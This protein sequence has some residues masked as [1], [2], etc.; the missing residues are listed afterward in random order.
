MAYFIFFFGD[1]VY[2]YF[3]FF[4]NITGGFYFI[5]VPVFFVFS[6]FYCVCFVCSLKHVSANAWDKQREEVI[7]QEVRRGRR[8]LQILAAEC[9]TAHSLIDTPFTPVTSNLLNNDNVL[10][11]SSHGWQRIMFT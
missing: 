9:C 8:S 7:L 10:F 3:I 5:L 2:F 1:F 4:T 11:L 6:G